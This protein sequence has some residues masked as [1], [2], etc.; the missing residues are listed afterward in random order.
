DSFSC[1]VLPVDENGAPLHKALIWMDIRAVKEAEEITAT[2]HKYLKYSGGWVSPE[3]MLPK[4]LW[5]KRNRQDIFN[6]A[7]RFIECTD[8]FTYKLTGKWTICMDHIA[9][10]WNYVKSEGGFSLDLLEQIGMVELMDKWPED[11]KCLGDFVGGLTKNAAQDLGLVEGIPVAQ[12]GIDAHIGMLGLGAVQAGELALIIGSSNCH[13][14]LSSDPV[15]VPGVWGPFDEAIIKGKWVLEGGQ[16][17]TGSIVKWFKDNFAYMQEMIAKVRKQNVYSVLDELAEKI[18]PGSDG[19]VLLDYWQGNRSPLSDPKARGAI[20]GLSLNHKNEHI[21][22]AI[23]EGT[24]YGTRHILEVLK[25][26]GFTVSKIYAGGGGAQSKLWLQIYADVC[27]L[28]I[29][30]TEETEAMTLGAAMTAAIGAGVYSD[31]SAATEKM[32]K[33]KSTIMPDRNNKLIYDFYYD[34]YIKTYERLKDMMHEVY[35]TVSL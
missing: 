7:Y 25:E 15:F 32:V 4:A 10:K 9:S 14:A 11:I 12:G 26:Q 18:A 31:Y 33:F 17:S 29:Y 22:R 13:M 30:I 35:E 34:K 3:W 6:R 24:A 2:R 21:V 19:L 20:W 23:Y 16:T 5:F 28:P 27:Q 1:T 8:W